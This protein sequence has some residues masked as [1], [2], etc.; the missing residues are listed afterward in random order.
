MLFIIAVLNLFDFN[1]KTKK[2]K[3][4]KAIIYT[5]YMPWRFYIGNL[6][7]YTHNINQ[8]RNAFFCI[9]VYYSLQRLVDDPCCVYCFPH[10][11]REC[12][13]DLAAELRGI[14]RSYV[15][16]YITTTTIYATDVFLCVSLS[17]YLYT[18]R[19]H[20][21][22]YTKYRV[23]H[24][25]FYSGIYRTV[26]ICSCMR[27]VSHITLKRP[28]IRYCTYRPDTQGLPSLYESDIKWHPS[29]FECNIVQGKFGINF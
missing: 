23:P 28:C 25:Y 8:M 2:P 10:F 24:V 14:H 22:L 4:K 1:L 19:I 13:I 18:G 6:S 27:S 17:L 21:L 3:N 29:H 5:S 15:V 12:I 11:S 9:H 26:L 7:Y 16:Y 20:V